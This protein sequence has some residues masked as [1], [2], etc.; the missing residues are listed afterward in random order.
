M[1][2]VITRF[3][4]FIETKQSFLLNRLLH[5]PAPSFTS[6]RNDDLLFLLNLAGF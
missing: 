5:A 4:F 6:V 3:R 2:Y 1:F